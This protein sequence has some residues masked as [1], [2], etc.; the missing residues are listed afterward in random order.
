VVGNGLAR[1]IA[2]LHETELIPE[3]VSHD[4]P[5]Q[6]GR[7]ARRVE[8]R[9]LDRDSA[10]VLGPAHREGH[11]INAKVEMSAADPGGLIL[12]NELEQK[13]R[14]DVCGLGVL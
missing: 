5:L 11:I 4:G 13:P 2:S 12:G 10:D 6:V 14:G 7:V 9:C 1:D 8:A 3:R